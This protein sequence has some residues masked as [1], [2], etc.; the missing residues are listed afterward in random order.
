MRMGRLILPLGVVAF[1]MIACRG[2]ELPTAPMVAD[3]SSLPG[4]PSLDR[5]G[6]HDS[7]SDKED[8]VRVLKRKA[9]ITRMSFTKVIGPAGLAVIVGS[10]NM[11]NP[12]AT[13]DAMLPAMLYLAA[14]F[15][16]AGIVYLALGIETKGRS[17]EEIEV[18]LAGQDRGR[19]ARAKSVAAE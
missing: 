3:Y 8:T 11:V 1:A 9:P 2:A 15:A 17:L 19:G 14:W 5:G 12:Q 6:Q 13:L 7:Q 16:L 4:G 18:L 10:S